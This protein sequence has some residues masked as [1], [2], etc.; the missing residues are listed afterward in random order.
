MLIEALAASRFYE[1][2]PACSKLNGNETGYGSNVKDIITY[3]EYLEE[4][5]EETNE[6]YRLIAIDK[7]N[8]KTYIKWL[9]QKREE[10]WNK[11]SFVAG[12]EYTV[13]DFLSTTEKH[14][15]ARGFTGGTGNYSGFVLCLGHIV[16]QD[17]A[18]VEQ[19]SYKPEFTY[20]QVDMM[21]SNGFSSWFW[22]DKAIGGWATNN[23]IIRVRPVYLS[24][25]FE[26]WK[27]ITDSVERQRTEK[28][29]QEFLNQS[30]TN[31]KE[32]SKGLAAKL[33]FDALK[34]LYQELSL[35]GLQDQELKLAF[36]SKYEFY[37]YE[38][39]ILAHEGRHSIEKKYL[40]DEFKKWSNE[41]REYHAKL[42]QIVFATEPRLEL[43][44]MLGDLGNSGHAKA[45][46]RIVGNAI[47]WIKKNQEQIA[48]YS[49]DRSEFSQIHLLSREQLK[50][51]YQ[52]A[53]YLS[54]SN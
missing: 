46:Q 39:S 41:E 48:G 12:K 17:K 52:Q 23:E 3:S 38:A 33:R 43:V 47:D 25:P 49:K 2:I 32:L 18:R 36:L 26:A 24:E 40:A 14:F 20:T 44:G 19:Y 5:R 6:Y 1:L 16:N 13:G 45:N 22:E 54:K 53:D 7:E 10:L 8:E 42:S 31:E 9:N 11:L 21:T 51:C 50:E 37:R 34:D 35:Q 4:I 29:I 15:G 27:T 30:G 28:R